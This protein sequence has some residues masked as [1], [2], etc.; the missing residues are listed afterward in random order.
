MARKY[1]NTEKDLSSFQKMSLIDGSKAYADL[2]Q[3]VMARGV[4]DRSYGYYTVI[5]T[6][7]LAGFFLSAYNVIVQTTPIAIIMWGLLFSF[8]VVQIGGLLHDAGHRTIAKSTR[9]ND[10][11][12]YLFGSLVVLAYG[13]WKFKHNKHHAHPNQEDEDPDVQ[14]PFSFTEDRYKGRGG[15]VGFIRKYQ[16]YL[17]YPFGTLAWLTLRTDGYAHFKTNFKKS[18]IPEIILFALGLIIWF[19]LPFIFF[20][21]SKALL[22]FA[23]VNTATGFYLFNIF[24]P[25]HKGMPQ[26]GKGVRISFI[27]Q[28]VLTSRNVKGHWL[29]DFIYM[30]LNYQ[31][32]HH[33][34]PNTPRNKLNKITPFV[35]DFC[36]K[37]KL[38]YTSVSVIQSNKI[39]LSE[40]LKVS[41]S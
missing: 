15:I 4:L 24:A 39:I 35:L 41:R 10:L 9:L 23:L 3:R 21:L 26:L 31:I 14:I 25:N 18:M 8:F 19:V 6:L 32:E 16:A 37:K 7:V 1:K 12:G 38:E 40:L 28:Q 2:R 30:G 33:L 22:L 17:Y 34:F 27:E 13:G 5:V 29:T 20:P 11:L 36:K